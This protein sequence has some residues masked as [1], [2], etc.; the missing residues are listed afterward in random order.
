MRLFRW[1]A[2]VGVIFPESRLLWLWQTSPEIQPVRSTI[3]YCNNLVW[4]DCT[5]LPYPYLLV[6][7]TRQHNM[8]QVSRFKTS[9]IFIRLFMGSLGVRGIFSFRL[10][11][12]S[13]YQ[14][15]E[16]YVSYMCLGSAFSSIVSVWRAF[17]H[18][19]MPCM[20]F[21]REQSLYPTNR[22]C[23]A[24]PLSVTTSN[25]WK[26]L[27]TYWSCQGHRSPPSRQAE[28]D[29]DWLKMFSVWVSLRY[30][31]VGVGSSQD[32]LY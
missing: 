28:Q 11:V 10:K 8:G 20:D 6:L 31:S 26:H 30:F 21:A 5:E 25:S 9:T 3:I 7:I 15:G 14:V 13:V 29:P 27:K 2:Y 17:K 22:S 32:I 1:E 23:V 19:L 24:Y 12:I 16:R 4:V 18:I